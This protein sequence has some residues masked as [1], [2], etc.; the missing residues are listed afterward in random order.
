MGKVLS[1]INLYKII[2]LNKKHK[3]KKIELVSKTRTFLLQTADDNSYMKWVKR[4]NARISPSHLF[5]G[6]AM[7]KCENQ[8]KKRYFV[9]VEYET[10]HVELRWYAD[11]KLQTFESVL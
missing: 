3:S 1:K 5:K 7:K 2:K 8:W 9:L 11:N 10:I 4:L 6:W